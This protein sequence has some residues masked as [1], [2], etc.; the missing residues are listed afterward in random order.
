MN[1]E[2]APARRRWGV[3]VVLGAVGAVVLLANSPVLSVCHI[4]IDGV[5]PRFGR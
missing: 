3:L 2:P 1:E 5:A 4:E